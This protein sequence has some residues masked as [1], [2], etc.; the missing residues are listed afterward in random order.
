MVNDYLRIENKG[1]KLALHIVTEL[2]L[3]GLLPKVFTRGILFAGNNT[4]FS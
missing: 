4:F 1:E 2:M 3:L